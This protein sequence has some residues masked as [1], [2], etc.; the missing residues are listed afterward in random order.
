MPAMRN[1]AAPIYSLPRL[2]AWSGLTHARLRALLAEGHVALLGGPLT[3]GKQPR[4]SALDAI[5]LAMA[6]ELLQRGFSSQEAAYAVSATVDG[7]FV[8]LAECSW[9]EIPRA[10]VLNRL[11]GLTVRVRV[12]PR[13]RL[14]ECSWR[15]IDAI[16]EPDAAIFLIYPL[17]LA[18]SVFSRIDAGKTNTPARNYTATPPAGES[19]IPVSRGFA[20][21]PGQ[22]GGTYSTHAGP[23]ALAAVKG[24]QP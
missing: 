20:A 13:G 21:R 7:V 4:G 14:A 2:A 5:R 22:A 16:A 11:H 9:L 18:E 6:K 3:P 8:G 24:V 23:P 17:R 19:L 15:R 1:A 10:V 12:C